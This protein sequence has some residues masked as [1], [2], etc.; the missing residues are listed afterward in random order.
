MRK[1]TRYCREDV[2]L[3]Q[4]VWGKLRMYHKPKTHAGVMAG[5]AKWTCAECGSEDVKTSKT[6]VTTKGTVQKQMR[7]KNEHCRKY[8][9]ISDKSH[10][11]YLEAKYVAKETA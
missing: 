6:L 7:C 10:K 9:T 8:Y 11:E 4:K 1:M 3:L 2:R 5:R